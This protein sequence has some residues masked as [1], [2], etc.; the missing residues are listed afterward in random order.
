MVKKSGNSSVFDEEDLLPVSV[1]ELLEECRKNFNYEIEIKQSE[2]EF[3]LPSVLLIEKFAI[4]R[5]LVIYINPKVKGK[6]ILSFLLAGEIINQ[7]SEHFIYGEEG[8]A[9]RKFFK[10]KSIEIKKR[11]GDD[12]VRYSPDFFEAYFAREKILSHFV[13]D[14]DLMKF[15]IVEQ[16]TIDIDQLWKELNDLL[17]SFKSEFGSYVDE[18][19]KLINILG[20]TELRIEGLKKMLEAVKKLDGAG[21]FVLKSKDAFTEIES[22]VMQELMEIAA[23]Y[24]ILGSNA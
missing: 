14:Y 15:I 9:F 17:G 12:W 8:D 21:A 6:L 19:G 13:A 1:K 2:V 5:K 16:Q 20:E 24:I 18:E 10:Q 22:N 11:L 23:E 4:D 7:L 3:K